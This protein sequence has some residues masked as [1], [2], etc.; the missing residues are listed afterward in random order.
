MGLAALKQAVET[1]CQMDSVLSHA[2]KEYIVQ[3]AFITGDRELTDKLIEELSQPEADRQAVYQRFH[4][5]TDFQPDWI[6]S[7]EKLLASLEMYRTQ[8]EKQIT[9]LTEI[10]SAYGIGLTEKEIGELPPEK[11]RDHAG[12]AEAVQR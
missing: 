8:E 9:V 2:D 10:L 6:R 12:K 11:I 1:V 3:F 4:T 7:I 5:V